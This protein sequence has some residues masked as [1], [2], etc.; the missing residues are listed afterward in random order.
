MDDPVGEQ[1]YPFLLGQY[2]RIVLSVYD[3]T[4]AVLSVF[5]CFALQMNMYY[6]YSRSVSVSYC[7]YL[8]DI[9][10]NQKLAL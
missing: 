10:L 4:E 8:V 1:S 9:T 2:L 5:A 6:E 3:V 7:T